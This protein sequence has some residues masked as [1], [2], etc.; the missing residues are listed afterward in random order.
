M[1]YKNQTA[2]E[3][4]KMKKVWSILA[5]KACREVNVRKTHRQKGKL[6]VNSFIDFYPDFVEA[7]KKGNYRNLPIFR[8]YVL[9]KEKNVVPEDIEITFVVDNSGSMNE[10]KIDAARRALSIALLSVEDFSKYLNYGKG[11]ERKVITVGTET[12]FFGSGY[13][14]I[15]DFDKNNSNLDN[16]IQIVKSIAGIDGSS[17]ATDDA[18][19]LRKINDEISAEDKKK[20]AHGDKIKIIIEITDGASGFPGLCKKEIVSIKEKGV[21]I[22]GIQIGSVSETSRNTF[23][24]IWNYGEEKNGIV[25]GRKIEKP[26]DVMLKTLETTLERE[27]L[28]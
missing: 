27:L 7:E 1:F 19:C 20:I 8:R 22:Y 11:A 5:G 4:E 13:E 10:E 16:D 28:R 6:D 23:E 12:Y 24:K 21:Q 9:E 14:K 18:A 3:R 26:P 15:K 25:L 2:K 17:G